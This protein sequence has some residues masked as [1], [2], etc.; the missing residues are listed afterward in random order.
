MGPGTTG[1]GAHAHCHGIAPRP[2]GLRTVVNPGVAA[3]VLAVD[4][5]VIIA[6]AA[7][8][9]IVLR[10]RPPWRSPVLVV[11]ITAAI[12][13]IVVVATMPAPLR[14]GGDCGAP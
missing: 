11:G 5:A 2:S 4:G 7:V 12:I 14:G 10:C 8:E 1:V 6:V 9:E 13:T 3:V